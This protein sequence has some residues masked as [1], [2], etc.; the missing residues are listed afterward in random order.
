MEDERGGEVVNENGR[1][2]DE[3]EHSFFGE[4]CVVWEL[5]HIPKV[6]Q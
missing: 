3:R 4:L 1:A 6:V 5:H 2:F